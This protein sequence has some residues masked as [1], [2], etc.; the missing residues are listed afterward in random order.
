M[1]VASPLFLNNCAEYIPKTPT[2]TQAK[3]S[4]DIIKLSHDSKYFD[5]IINLRDDCFNTKSS[6]GLLGSDIFIG[7]SNNKIYG[8]FS[9]SLE[10]PT[11]AFIHDMCVGSSFRGAGLGTKLFNFG[12]S[13]IENIPALKSMWL[14]VYTDNQAALKLYLSAGFEIESTHQDGTKLVYSMRK[15]IPAQATALSVF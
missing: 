6:S 9:Y 11:V 12:I 1:L 7:I 15:K 8:F 14:E 3:L 2:K 5:D 10:S 13:K 4:F